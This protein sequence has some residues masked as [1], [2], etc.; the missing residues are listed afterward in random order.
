MSDASPGL[1]A[2]L[3]LVMDLTSRCNLRCAYC[4]FFSNPDE[5]SRVDM[6]A[7]RWVELVDE[8]GRCGVLQLTLRGGEALL[9]P[10]FWPV[11]DAAVRNRMRF[12]LLTNGKLF[13]DDVAE[14]IAASGRCDLVKISLDGPEEV[15]D[16]VRG[17]ASHAGALAGIAAARKAGLPL[18]VTCAVHKFN[19]RLLPEIV[20]YLIDELGLPDVSFSAVTLCDAPEYALSEA[21]FRAAVELICRHERPEMAKTGMY[22]G[23][24]VWRKMLNGVS[25]CGECRLLR[26]QMNVLADGTFVPCAALSGISLGKAGEVSIR[27]AWKSL[28]S[29]SELSMRRCPD[30]D[31]ASCR[32]RGVCRGLCAGALDRRTEGDWR[33]FCLRRYMDCGGGGL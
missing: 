11:V 3:Q 30:P 2:P 29:Q 25:E 32:Y 7:E 24:V 26:M 28:A 9:S 5:C 18:R 8:A 14:R 1:S 19:W 16:R 10:A 6:A 23:I 17:R 4:C 31:S 13:T 12:K 22:G 33:C 21:D 15:H 20:A 27:D